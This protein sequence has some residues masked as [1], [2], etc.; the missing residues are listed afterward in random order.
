MSL[1]T[2]KFAQKVRITY[3]GI[4]SETVFFEID[5]MRFGFVEVSENYQFWDFS[6]EKVIIGYR[7]IASF[8]S[9]Y[10]RAGATGSDITDVINNQTGVN[11]RIE[12]IGMT[13]VS[14]NINQVANTININNQRI[15]PAFE[16]S[17]EAKDLVSSVPSWFKFTKSK[18]GYL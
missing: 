12:D 14:V 1:V 13:A 11:F 8:D 17:V 7:F 15:I 5:N 16:F 6:K 10:L 18:P 9:R 3:E 4:S 2:A